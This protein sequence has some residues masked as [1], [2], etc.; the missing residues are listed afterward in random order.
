MR[1]FVW[2]LQFHISNACECGQRSL[3]HGTEHP[4]P[5]AQARFHFTPG[6]LVLSQGS[7]KLY[8]KQDYEIHGVVHRY[9][10]TLKYYVLN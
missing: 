3:Y 5:R 6:W 10:I 1:D 2:C 9:K 4:P 8:V 7:R